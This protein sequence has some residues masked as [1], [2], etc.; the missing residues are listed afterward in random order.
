MN[1]ITAIELAL[2]LVF[3]GC[4]GEPPKTPPLGAGGDQ[5]MPASTDTVE[6]ETA[7]PVA[8]TATGCAP[9]PCQACGAVAMAGDASTDG[10]IVANVADAGAVVAVSA[11]GEITGKITT[12]PAYL[13][14]VSVVWLEDAPKEPTRGMAGRVD[15][16]QGAFQPMVSVITVGGTITFVNT[17]PF[18]HNVFSPDGK[19]NLGTLAQNSSAA[20]RHFEKPGAFTL[21][22]NLHPN[23]IGYLV[24]S[25]SSY[26][27]KANNTGRYRIKDV[28]AGTYKI[29]AWAPRLA[30]V[31]QSV[32]LAGAEA[33]TD[34]ELHR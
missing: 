20:P 4:E 33:T 13:S 15:N 16:H 21:L 23:M 6:P 27:A 29:T 34:F 31:T 17:D 11:R 32:T 7:N 30:T 2:A 28:P 24:V 19:F 12:T 3:V 5:P 8:T 1:S 22:C 26:F 10:A 18:P 14:S 9:C 25:P